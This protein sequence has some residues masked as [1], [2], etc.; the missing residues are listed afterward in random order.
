MGAIYLPTP[1]FNR[2]QPLMRDGGATSLSEETD[3]LLIKIDSLLWPNPVL[4]DFKCNS[5]D[6]LLL[7]YLILHHVNKQ[8]ETLLIKGRLPIPKPLFMVT[9]MMMLVV[10]E[11]QMAV[12]KIDL[13]IVG[14]SN[15]FTHTA[16]TH[17]L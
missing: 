6:K 10:V 12:I 17:W 1:I 2:P 9:E 3:I 5:S 14:P 7:L 16:H 15:E 11:T 8:T 13:S 4:S